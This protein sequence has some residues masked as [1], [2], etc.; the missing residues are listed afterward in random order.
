MKTRSELMLIEQNIT[1]HICEY[2]EENQAATLSGHY[3][4]TPLCAECADEYRKMMQLEMR[5]LKND[6]RGLF[7]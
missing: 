1:E 2:C 4:E 5:Q 7:G 3:G 6:L